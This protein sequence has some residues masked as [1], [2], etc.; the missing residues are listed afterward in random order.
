LFL[1]AC[2]GWQGDQYLRHRT[3]ASRAARETSYGFGRPGA[4]WREVR[5]KGIQVAWV[6]DQHGA[7]ITLHVQCAEQGDSSLEQ[8]TDH[9]RIDWT[10]WEVVSQQA[11]T[12]L[13]RDA[14]RTVVDAKLDGVGYR[15]EF[16]V[17][18]KSGC[19]FDMMYSAPPD[20]FTAGHAAFE[21]VV[22]GLRHPVEGE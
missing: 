6:S 14:L 1:P 21:S 11:M 7:V 22:A 17:V 9:M 12:M 10:A 20:R 3:P 13:G 8:Y 5:E 18:K 15:N 19:L 4:G 2:R 16:I